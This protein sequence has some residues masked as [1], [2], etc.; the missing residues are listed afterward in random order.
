MY[1]I[2]DITTIKLNQVKPLQIHF[3]IIPRDEEQMVLEDMKR[4]GLDSIDPILIRR[5]SPLEIEQSKTRYP[6]AIYEIVDGHTRYR[7][8]KELGWTE[9][10]AR[11]IECTHDEALI[12]NYRKN[13][14]RGMVDPLRTAILV[15]LLLRKGYSPLRI[16]EL[17][18]L[19]EPE[20][21]ELLKISCVNKDILKELLEKTERERKIV[22]KDALLALIRTAD[23]NEQAKLAETILNGV[24][25][26]N[27]TSNSC[28]PRHSAEHMILNAQFNPKEFYTTEECPSCGTRL[29][30]Y[31]SKKRIEW[32]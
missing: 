4:V 2:S 11:I 6:E 32:L 13:R 28:L 8:A 7:L 15:S 1:I 3:S 24:K 18:S 5:L 20:V 23:E 27:S 12:L 10:K 16:A 25:K 22:P 21:L 30:I 19:P 9:I 31:W 26:T 17:L 14:A 29:R